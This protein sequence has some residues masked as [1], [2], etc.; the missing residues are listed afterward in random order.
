ML[1]AGGR[2][3][4]GDILRPEVGMIRDVIAL[5]RFA[6]NIAATRL[7]LLHGNEGVAAA[8]E[9]IRAFA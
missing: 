1:K 4:V 3:V 6:L 5:L 9:V 7:I 8:G 2:L